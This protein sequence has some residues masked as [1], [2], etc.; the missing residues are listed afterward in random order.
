MLFTDT[1]PVG[2]TDQV[3]VS[4]TGVVSVNNGVVTPIA[5]GTCTIT[6]TCGTQTANCNV[7]VSGIEEQPIPNG[8]LVKLDSSSLTNSSSTWEDLSGNG[9][10]FTLS[11]G[12]P[13]VSDKGLLMTSV[14]VKGTKPITLNGAFTEYYCVYLK[15]VTTSAFCSYNINNVTKYCANADSGSLKINGYSGNTMTS[16]DI[17]NPDI[18]QRIAVVRPSEGDTQVYLNGAL[19]GTYNRGTF[20]CNGNYDLVLGASS[21][22]N[23]PNDKGNFT[24]KELQIFNRVLSAEEAIK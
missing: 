18:L 15:N 16:V 21:Y 24:L 7:T 8:L 12:T 9:V 17:S 4:P 10:N 5:N 22:N 1:T 14:K 20:E 11:D 6:A 3:T 23:F 13:D 2:D 19:Q